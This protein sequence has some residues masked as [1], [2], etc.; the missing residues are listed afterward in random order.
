M[1]G[2]EILNETRPKTIHM[3]DWRHDT[4]RAYD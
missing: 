3:P 2:R 1:K 4:R